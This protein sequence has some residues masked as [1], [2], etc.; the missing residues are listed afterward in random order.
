MVPYDVLLAEPAH[1]VYAD[2]I[3]PFND[4]RLGAHQRYALDI[5]HGAWFEVCKLDKMSV[6][7]QG[8]AVVVVELRR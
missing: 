3:A 6:R 8:V 1:K 4:P 7:L 2:P 5:I